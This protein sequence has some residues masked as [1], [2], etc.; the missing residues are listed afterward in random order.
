MH[1]TYFPLFFALAGIVGLWVVVLIVISHLGGWASLAE[2]YRGLEPFA[3]SSW[4]FQSGQF[5][6]LANYNNCLTIGADPRGLFLSVF[7]LFRVAHPPLFVPWREISVSRKRI[8]WV[9]QVKFLL[10][11]ELKIPLTIRESL[12]QK[13]QTAAG[14]SWPAKSDSSR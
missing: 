13:L 6:W 10:G 7:P 2:Q 12:A 11:N 5:R 4:S 14:S 8:F 9:N 1:N 3:G